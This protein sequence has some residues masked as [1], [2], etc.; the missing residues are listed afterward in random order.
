MFL[1]YVSVVHQDGAWVDDAAGGEFVQGIN[2]LKIQTCGPRPRTK[3]E[4]PTVIRVLGGSPVAPQVGIGRRICCWPRPNQPALETG[5]GRRGARDG[6]PMGGGGLEVQVG[7]HLLWEPE[8][9]GQLAGGPQPRELPLQGVDL[10]EVAADVVV[11][12]PLAGRQPEAPRGI[13]GARAR[14]A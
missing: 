7:A 9:P 10:R 2:L 13:G 5:W 11:A 6:C 8:Q 14:A 1:S 3:K 4:S 12:A